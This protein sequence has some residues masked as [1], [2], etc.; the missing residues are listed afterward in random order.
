MNPV[1]ILPFALLLTACAIGPVVTAD[2][3]GLGNAAIADVLRYSIFTGETGIDYAVSQFINKHD[4][5]GSSNPRSTL[6]H[7]GFV[8]GPEPG[9]TCVY[10]GSAKSSFDDP[11]K[12]VIENYLTT[13]RLDV[14]WRDRK[15]DVASQTARTRE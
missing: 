4:V 10:E 2:Y 13:V 6:E 5:M 7:L 8:C 11:E 12:P 9:S 1:R 14:S 3:T 15:I